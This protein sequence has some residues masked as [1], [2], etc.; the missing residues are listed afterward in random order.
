MLTYLNMGTRQVLP[1]RLAQTRFPLEILGAVLDKD[2]GE[3]MEYRKIM[4]KPKYRQIYRNSYPKE[5]GRLAQGMPCIVEGTNTMSFIDKQDIPVN[6]WKDVTYGRVV[7]EYCPD[8]SDPYRT[9]LT[10]GGDRVN[11]PGY[12]GTPKVRLTTVKL[13]LNSIVSAI[14]AHF[15]TMD[16]KGFT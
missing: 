15:M 16:I 7:V 3:L 9:R 8:K 4:R 6:R 5:I 14:N 11:Y 13:L 2:T 1:R 10:I 12:C